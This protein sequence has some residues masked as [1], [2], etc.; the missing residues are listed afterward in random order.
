MDSLSRVVVKTR[1][2]IGFWHV[3][4][5]EA[6]AATRFLTMA[7]RRSQVPEKITTHGR[8]AN[9]AAIRS[10]HAEHGTAITIRQVNSFNPM[11]AQDHRRVTGVRRPMLGFTFLNAPVDSCWWRTPAHAAERLTGRQDE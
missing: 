1:Q 7:I 4:H 8:E 9:V 5:G 11:R 10:D 3:E 6:H 2:T